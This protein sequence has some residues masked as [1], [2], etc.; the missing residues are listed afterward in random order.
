MVSLGKAGMYI[1]LVDTP[2]I[3]LD[4]SIVSKFANGKTVTS[5]VVVIP[6]DFDVRISSR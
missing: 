5:I 6:D 1:K 3:L 4:T 2:D